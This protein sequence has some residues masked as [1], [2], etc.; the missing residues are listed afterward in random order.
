M[1][2]GVSIQKVVDGEWSE[3]FWE[4]GAAFSPSKFIPSS[5][6]EKNVFDL[7]LTISGNQ[8]E[9]TIV[10]D[11][12]GQGKIFNYGPIEIQGNQSEKVGF[13]SYYQKKLNID[14]L[15]VEEVAGIPLE[16]FSK[17]GTPIPMTGLTNFEPETKLTATVEKSYN[18]C[19]LAIVVRLQGGMEQDQYPK[20]G[21]GFYLKPKSKLYT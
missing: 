2:Q 4:K 11:P 12:S 15:K 19:S 1:R 13:F 20:K 16:I 5:N 17:Y 21:S 14:F 8:L 7:S 18:R 9:F 6:E 3:V 10:G